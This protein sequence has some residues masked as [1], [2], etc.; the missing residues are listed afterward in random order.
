MFKKM[1][2]LTTLV[3]T[4]VLG[5][6]ARPTQ[7]QAFGFVPTA[8]TSSW[9]QIQAQATAIS[10]QAA[11]VSAAAQNIQAYAAQIQNNENNPAVNQWAGQIIALAAQ[12]EH[13]AAA[14]QSLAATINQRIDNS[15]GTTLALSHDIGVMADRIGEMADRIL[16]TEGQI[17]VM[18]DRIV[19][20]EY[21]ISDS[22]LALA[23]MIQQS[24]VPVTNGASNISN[25]AAQI[26]NLLP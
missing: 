14:I 10:Q 2:L 13:D 12:T 4:L 16:W 5:A 6:F 21:L 7:A 24:G 11:A 20:S 25:S 26:R 17:G 23:H 18:A 15:E 9:N 1:L 3:F 22:S 19:E 8:D